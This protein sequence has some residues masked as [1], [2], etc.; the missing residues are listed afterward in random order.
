MLLPS[1]KK[2]GTLFSIENCFE[3]V[4][5]PEKAVFSTR[6]EKTVMRPIEA[7]NCKRGLSQ[8]S[9]KGFS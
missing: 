7:K 9:Q 8:D 6:F 3:N 1:F 4:A 2:E 5:L